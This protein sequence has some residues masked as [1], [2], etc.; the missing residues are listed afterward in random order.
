MLIKVKVLI[1]C[2]D[3]DLWIYTNKLPYENQRILDISKLKITLSKT[4][5]SVHRLLSVVQYFI[6]CF[7]RK[8][9]KSGNLMCIFVVYQ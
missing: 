1:F 2:R 5:D 3:E 7:R 8:M 6:I 9:A 4:G